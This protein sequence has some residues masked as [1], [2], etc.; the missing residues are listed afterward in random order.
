VVLGIAQDGGVPQA[1]DTAAAGWDVPERRALVTCLGLVDPLSGER[2]LF[3]ATPDLPEQLRRLDV[4][5]PA[6][7]STERPGL[8]GIFVTHAHFG[9]YTGLGFLGHEVMGAR[10]VPVWA[11]AR[12][13]QFLRTNGPW[14]QLVRLA[15]IELRELSAGRA[16]RLNER[17]SVTPLLVPHRQ[18][19]S[20]VV[21]LRIDGPERSILFLPDIDSWEEWDAQGTRIE[22]V[23]RGLDLA[24]LDGTFWANGEIPGRD[25]SG[26]P[27][28]FLVHSLERFAALPDAERAKI[29]FLHLNHTNPAL[30]E[31]P[32]RAALRAAGFE[33]ARE[34]ELFEL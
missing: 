7:A 6:P 33:I 32:E 26:F 14:S 8:T 15:N 27:H 3:E 9:H 20:E 5:A 18:E 29:R 23:L 16:V 19:F 4:L 21:A 25:M 1:G 24:F 34:G 28:P 13:A 31:G 2:W 11:M 22:D 10:A 30:W 17:L 12:M